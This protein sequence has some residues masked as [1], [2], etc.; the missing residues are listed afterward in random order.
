MVRLYNAQGTMA[1]QEQQIIIK[2]DESTSG[3]A[4]L[5]T[6]RILRPSSGALV[7]SRTDIQIEAT[8]EAGILFVKVLLNGK[9]FAM[10]NEPPFRIPLD[11]FAISC[12]RAPTPSPRR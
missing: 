10:M 11:P 12:S 3:V 6:V 1:H 9:G 4:S 5:P 7:T 2:T 8:A